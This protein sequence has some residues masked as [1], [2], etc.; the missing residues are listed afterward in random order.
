M[1]WTASLAA[2]ALACGA[3]TELGVVDASSPKDAAPPKEA[4]TDAPVADVAP[5]PVACP[6]APTPVLLASGIQPTYDS[7]L[8]VDATSVYMA[9]GQRITRFPKCAPGAPQTLT[10]LEPNAG[11]VIVDAG[12]VYF[13]DIV[14]GGSVK[15]VPAGGG[16]TTTLATAPTKLQPT[17]L[18]KVGDQLY[19]LLIPNVGA[20][21]VY[22]VPA[23]GG[24]P[25]FIG[26][27]WGQSIAVDPTTVYEFGAAVL[28]SR[29]ALGG[30]ATT[31]APASPNGALA[32]DDTTI[33]FS[34]WGGPGTVSSIPKQGGTP[35]LLSSAEGIPTYVALDADFVY[36]VNDGGNVKRTSKFGGPLEVLSPAGAA[37]LGLDD[38]SVYYSTYGGELYR[39]DK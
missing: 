12:V 8:A 33:F 27:A 13:L 16:P 5:P 1:K 23:A 37:G 26:P 15:S 18:R 20:Y 35:T 36:W 2:V 6:P 31:I 14:L 17:A 10:G 11:R 39:V 29:P 38:T 19:Y 34:G 28:E 25:F 4:G 3:R 30:P 32:V 9:D 21:G 22:S 24:S 7:Q